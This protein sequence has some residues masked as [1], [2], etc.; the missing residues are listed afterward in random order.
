[1]GDE[2][3]GCRVAV[4]A[5]LMHDSESVTGRGLRLPPAGFL[6][7]TE[8]CRSGQGD[9]QLGM[10]LVLDGVTEGRTDSEELKV[11]R[12]PISHERVRGLNEGQEVDGG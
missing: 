2:E 6:A 10:G 11:S 4:E 5:Q 3:R 9:P 12:G 7:R 8:K 1:M